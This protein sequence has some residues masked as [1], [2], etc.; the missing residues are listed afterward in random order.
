M[1]HNRQVVFFFQIPT[2]Q[3]NRQLMFWPKNRSYKRPP[4]KQKTEQNSDMRHLET[5]LEFSPA[6]ITIC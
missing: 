3:C 5:S 6:L 2:I 1:S 4:N